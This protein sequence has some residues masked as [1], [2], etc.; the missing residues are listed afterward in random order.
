MSDRLH[1]GA[2]WSGFFVLFFVF[3]SAKFGMCQGYFLLKIPCWEGHK[4]HR[5]MITCCHPVKHKI[6][7]EGSQMMGYRSNPLGLLVE[8]VKREEDE[9]NASSHGGAVG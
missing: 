2:S 4:K 8:G 5:L 9:Q 6:D 3:I 7:Y 1:A